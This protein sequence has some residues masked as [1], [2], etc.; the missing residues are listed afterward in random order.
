[1]M[2]NLIRLQP[3]VGKDLSEMTDEE[4]IAF[5]LEDDND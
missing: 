2:G 5:L 3:R 1:M 4:I